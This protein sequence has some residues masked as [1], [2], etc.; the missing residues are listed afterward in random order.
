MSTVVSWFKR[1]SNSYV[2]RAAHTY[3]WDIMPRA[4]TS[5]IW[6]GVRLEERDVIRF[7]Q[8]YCR[9]TDV[10][11]RLYFDLDGVTPETRGLSITVK[12]ACGDSSFEIS[13]TLNHTKAFTLFPQIN[14]PKRWMPYGY[15][16]ANVYDC[17][18]TLF[19]NGETISE[20]E[21]SFGLRTVVLDR[22]DRTDGVNGKFRFLVNGVEIMC[23]GSNWVPLDAFH[24]RRRKIRRG[25]C[26]CTRYR[27]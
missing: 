21:F 16:D 1:E 23:K 17:K 18:A 22:T 13:Q 9:T 24:S 6:R 3:G 20:K 12:G 10:S 2:R 27:L 14:D 8:I 5:G 11:V 19:L 26:T 4:V 25:A 7:S 15:G